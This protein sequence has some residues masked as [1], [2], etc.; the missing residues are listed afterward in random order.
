MLR[1]EKAKDKAD[2][3]IKVAVYDLQA[4]HQ[5][6]KEEVSVFYYKSKLN[7]L[8]LTVYD[9]HTNGISCYVWDKSHAHRG[10]YEIG[11]CIFKYLQAMDNTTE[12]IDVVFY[13]DNWAGQQKNKFMIAMYLFA[14][15][16]LIN[17]RSITH[18]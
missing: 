7:V 4:V 5:C 12:D 1:E 17:I 11:T 8:N 3:S 2:R 15:Q 9:L 13:S 16:N 14:V 6:P 18:K 10:A